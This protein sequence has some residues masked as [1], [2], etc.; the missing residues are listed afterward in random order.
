METPYN[1][2]PNILR[3]A[4]SGMDGSGSLEG[5]YNWDEAYQVE[6]LTTSPN[7]R[8]VSGAQVRY[9]LNNIPHLLKFGQGPM[10]M[11]Y[12]LINANEGNLRYLSNGF[13]QE[14]S[15]A[16]L[17]IRLDLIMERDSSNT[18]RYGYNSEKDVYEYTTPDDEVN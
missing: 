9:V 2:N 15:P 12:V 8:T 17:V 4:L 11:R 7:E 3:S 5:D 13:R 18:M 14:D 6:Y 16:L 10:E 1:V